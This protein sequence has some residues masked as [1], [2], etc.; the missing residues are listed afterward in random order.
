MNKSDPWVD[1]PF[2]SCIDF[3][4]IQDHTDGRA[5]KCIPA[6]NATSY[7]RGFSS[8]ILLPKH[9]NIHNVCHNIYIISLLKKNAIATIYDVV[10]LCY[11]MLLL[12]Y[13]TLLYS[14]HKVIIYKLYDIHN[15][16]LCYSWEGKSC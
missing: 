7:Y 13:S 12:L 2:V 9:N 1:V 15:I 16:T 5:E 4:S 10:M 11:V 3:L 6:K 14:I 8:S